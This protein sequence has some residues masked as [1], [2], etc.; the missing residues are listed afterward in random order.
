MYTKHIDDMLEV[1]TTQV[2]LGDGEVAVEKDSGD[3]V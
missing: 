1:P 3:A 2:A